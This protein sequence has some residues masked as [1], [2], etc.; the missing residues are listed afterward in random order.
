MATATS[1]VTAS[2]LEARVAQLEREIAELRRLVE[3]PQPE[4][5]WLATFGI[6][7]DYD[8]FPEVQRLGREYREREN[9]ASLE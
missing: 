7:A 5:P 6:F 9:Q 4:K 3:Q 8:D 2:E 1:T